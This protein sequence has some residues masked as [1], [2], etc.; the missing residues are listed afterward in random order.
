MGGDVSLGELNWRG[1]QRKFYSVDTV[2]V[3]AHVARSA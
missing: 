1:R 3:L 2:H